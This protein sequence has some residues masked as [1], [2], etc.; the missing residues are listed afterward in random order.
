M[1]L[2]PGKIKGIRT[3]PQPEPCSELQRLK[4]TVL[5]AVLPSLSF[6]P[7]IEQE[8]VSI[9]QGLDVGQAERS[10]QCFPASQPVKELSA[11]RVEL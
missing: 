1:W 7:R 4:G 9:S 2:T 10:S 11:E 8:W 6:P 3:E 5:R